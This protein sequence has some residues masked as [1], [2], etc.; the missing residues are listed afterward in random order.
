MNNNHISHS[1]ISSTARNSLSHQYFTGLSRDLHGTFT[2]LSRDL[3]LC[4][5]AC[6]GV[7][8]PTH[9]RYTPCLV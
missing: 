3:Q 9:T 5:N 1:A 8:G 2:R 4:R 6:S 7:P